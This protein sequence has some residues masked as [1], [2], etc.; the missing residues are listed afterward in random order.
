MLYTLTFFFTEHFL[1]IWRYSLDW[2]FWDL[3]LSGTIWRV[4]CLNWGRWCMAIGPTDHVCLP[5]TLPRSSFS[6]C[7]YMMSFH[8]LLSQ[9]FY[10]MQFSASLP[11]WLV[12]IVDQQSDWCKRM[13]VEPFFYLICILVTCPTS[14]MQHSNSSLSFTFPPNKFTLYQER[15]KLTTQKGVVQVYISCLLSSFSNRAWDKSLN[16]PK[17]AVCVFLLS[18]QCFTSRINHLRSL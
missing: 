8:S 2:S 5:K 15:A 6:V 4:P 14:Q 11:S 9:L 12:Y 18:L 13:C 3:G 7:T 17:Y 1:M 10:H 16:R